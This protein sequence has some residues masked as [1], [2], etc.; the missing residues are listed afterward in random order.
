MWVSGDGALF[1]D[2]FSI[3]TRSLAYSLSR[4][5]YGNVFVCLC[6]AQSAGGIRQTRGHTTARVYATRLAGRDAG[7]ELRYPGRRV[8]GATG[9]CRTW[10][11]MGRDSS[12]GTATLASS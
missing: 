2:H 5:A 7:H 12:V 3:C 1:Q 11:D 4:L 10:T 9:S 8:S 6:V